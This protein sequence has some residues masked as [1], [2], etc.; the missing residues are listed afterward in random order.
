MVMG[1]DEP[2]DKLIEVV[3]KFSLGDSFSFFYHFVEGVVAA[4]FEDDVDVLG[5]LE[6]VVEEE[7]VFVL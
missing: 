5:V 4:Y 6:D 7:D 3:L 1:V 2:L